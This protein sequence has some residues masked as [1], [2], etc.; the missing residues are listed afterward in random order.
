MKSLHLHI[1]RIVVEGL[2]KSGQ[3][4]FASAL[5]AELHRIA[6]GG[7]ADAFTR[8][9]RKRIQALNAGKLRAGAT[10]E[11]AAAQVARSIRESILPIGQVNR[12]TAGVARSASASGAQ[13]R[14]SAGEAHRHG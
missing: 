8:N 11:Q 2:S 4:R 9:T 3:R 10:P 1:D 12:R 5:E 7:I 14:P 6:E 13:V